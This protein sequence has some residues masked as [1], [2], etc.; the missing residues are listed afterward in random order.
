MKFKVDEHLPVELADLLKQAGHDAVT[1]HDERLGGAKDDELA[2]VCQREG[3]AFVTFDLGFS[4]IRSYPPSELS[5]ARC[6]STEVPGQAACS[7]V[8]ERLLEVLKTESLEHCL[9]IV[10]ESCVR[11]RRIESTN[12]ST[13]AV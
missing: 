7:E 11:I 2:P 3:R 12:S 6:V 8:C 1:V 13:G 5:G 9:W 4:D 10:E